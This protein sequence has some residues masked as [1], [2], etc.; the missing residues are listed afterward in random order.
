MALTVGELRIQLEAR[1][2]AFQ[3]G[4]RQAQGRVRTFATG[5]RQRLAGAG[6]AFRG[7]ASTVFKLTAVI[8]V[9]GGA[10][11]GLGLARFISS[12]VRAAATFEQ[13]GIA[14]RVLTGSAEGAAAILEDVN[15]LTVQTPFGLTEIAN[16]ARSVAV[17]FGENTE[18]VS[19]FTAIAADLAAAFGRPVEQIGENLVRAFS[20]GLGAADAFREAG[21][22]ASILQQTGATDVAKI[23]ATELAEALRQL[24]EEGGKAFGAAAAQ[25]ES[26]GGALSNTSIAVQN[27]QRSFGEA[28]QPALVDIL[29]NTIQPAFFRLEALIRENSDTI[30]RFAAR[31][32][33]ALIRGFKSF[34]GVISSVLRG[35]GFL[36]KGFRLLQLGG[37]VVQ[38]Q[39]V[40]L[41]GVFRIA[42]ATI[43]A[44]GGIITR[45]V[46][47][48]GL[49]LTGRFGA[50][51]KEI[52]G[53]KDEIAD[54][55]TT[56][57]DS[58]SDAGNA[59]DVAVERFAEFSAAGTGL[60]AVADGLDNLASKGAG[61]VTS[62]TAITAATDKNTESTKANT[63]ANLDGI[64][65]LERR[66]QTQISALN[67]LNKTIQ[68]QAQIAGGRTS[69][70]QREID[71]LD[72]QI[73]KTGQLA[74]ADQDRA[75]QA[76]ALQALAARRL[77]LTNQIND[78]EAVLPNVLARINDQI[79]NLATLDPDAAVK[80]A[81]EIQ[82]A[83]VAAAG[84]PVV[85]L[86]AATN[87]SQALREAIPEAALEAQGAFA[88]NLTQNVGTA[89]QNSL[90]AGGDNF[91]QGFGEALLETTQQSLAT[92]FSEA[93]DDIGK[94]LSKTFAESSEKGFLA[95]IG[96]PA[97]AV[98]A[99]GIVG[100]LIASAFQDEQVTSTAALSSA[101]GAAVESAQRTRGI[102]VG[103]QEVG[104]A[105]V[106]RSIQDAFLE[107]ERRLGLIANNTARIAANTSASTNG[108]L[109]TSIDDA[110]EILANESPSFV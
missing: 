47:A 45:V 109:S 91:L 54:F 88:V 42:G 62:T 29:V 20:S 22:T 9:L 14:L 96:G 92:A 107:S 70:I 49:A 110:S 75:R 55:A 87:I 72:N 10:L 41:V 67:A 77:V 71:A 93:L 97:V 52:T 16:A 48:I 5:V 32:F 51:R 73:R 60:D 81:V 80:F 105:Q 89:F 69:V 38:A 37:A 65:V 12:G 33:P 27:F 83:L 17:V 39:I 46:S 95:G 26:L 28:I 19:E 106:G 3:R 108:S 84:D 53:I 79:A 1:T 104:I 25:A 4:L 58:F 24:T 63:R 56:A 43:G 40:A 100:A 44:A 50:A 94:G 2:R 36:V 30:N 86:A 76:E 85:G 57:Q 13:I 59:V 78:A 31:V 15:R 35:L 61:L 102:I 98:A 64:A 8:G 66:T 103:P 34:V 101:A 7:L 11:A 90:Q 68:A 99:V 74:V 18:A 23:S 82:N 21:I 6:G